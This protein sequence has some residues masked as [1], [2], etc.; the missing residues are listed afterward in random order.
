[1]KKALWSNLW[2]IELIVKGEVKEKIT[3]SLQ[4]FR[5]G[6][7]QAFGETHP[8]LRMLGNGI[9]K[10]NELKTIEFG[11]QNAHFKLTRDTG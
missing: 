8:F 7:I 10:Q 5:R 4:N 3:M 2:K 9:K 1:M 11:D 6:M